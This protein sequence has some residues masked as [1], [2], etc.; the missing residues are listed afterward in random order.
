MKPVVSK[1]NHFDSADEIAERLLMSVPDEL[2]HPNLGQWLKRCIEWT[3]CDVARSFAVAAQRGIEQAAELIRDPDFEQH[4]RESRKK[5]LKRWREDEA[6]RDFERREAE[7]FPTAAQI[8]QTIRNCD[9]QII[10][11]RE[12]IAKYEKRILEL[13]SKVPADAFDEPATK[14]TQ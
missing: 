3:I 9:N 6:K 5:Q 11:H 10:Y 13:H 7:A 2:K 4:R 14:I 8:E 1:R 12:Q